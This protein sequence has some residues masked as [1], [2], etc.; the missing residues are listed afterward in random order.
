MEAV[1]NKKARFE[2]F[3]EET[4]EAPIPKA[5]RHGLERGVGTHGESGGFPGVTEGG[6]AG[7][8]AGG[9]AFLQQS[10]VTH[11]GLMAVACQGVPQL[12][13]QGNPQVEHGTGIGG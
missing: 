1:L 4:F 9:A 8:R 7:I 12:L 11:F 10:G 13:R 5:L 3:V 2:Y 6:I